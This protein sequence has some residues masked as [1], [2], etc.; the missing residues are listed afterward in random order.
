LRFASVV[1]VHKQRNLSKDVLEMLQKNY[2][3]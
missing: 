2:K 1:E 3:N